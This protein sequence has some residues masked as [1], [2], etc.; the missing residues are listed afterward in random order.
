[1]NG[2]SSFMNVLQIICIVT[3]VRWFLLASNM[4]QNTWFVLITKFGLAKDTLF[5][6]SV[7]CNLDKLCVL[8][9]VKG[10]GET[11]LSG[12]D[13]WDVSLMY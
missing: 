5:Y 4:S 12:I 6:T 7:F 8:I 3:L 10:R 13:W 9:D 11:I 1:M 2:F